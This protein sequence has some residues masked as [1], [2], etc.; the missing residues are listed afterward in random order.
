MMPNAAVP[1]KSKFGRLCLRA[2]LAGA[3]ALL[4]AAAAVGDEAIRVIVPIP[5]GAALDLMARM[6]A[7]EMGR[8]PFIVENR[9]GAGSIVGTELA[10]RASP[11]GRTV[12]MVGTGFIITPL[13]HK[14]NYDPLTS[15]EPICQLFNSP[16][17][18]AVNS[19]SPYRSLTDLL[20]AAKAKPGQLTLGSIGPG[21]T[22]HL[23]FEQLK[24]DAKVDMTFVPYPGTTPA[25]DALLGQHITA[26]LGE[27]S[28]VRAQM[29]A[30]T[31]RALAV[32]SPSR[33]DGLSDV[34]TLAELGFGNVLGELWWGALAPAHTPRQKIEQLAGWYQAAM[35]TPSIKT[36]LRDLGL[37]EAVSC[38]A[39]FGSFL[40]EQFELDRH[41]IHQVGTKMN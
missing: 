22:A 6:L 8:T 33:L 34:P 20:N 14:T 37:Y 10:A 2:F 24:R 38:G 25:F 35:R 31:L 12:I 39:K 16:M 21:S 28:F 13:L 19:K 36:K 15:F 1:S 17:V 5:P 3:A 4:F 18:I 41:I 30:G 29:K 23:A 9:P 40:R 27:S 32:A 11:N 26:Y 7:A